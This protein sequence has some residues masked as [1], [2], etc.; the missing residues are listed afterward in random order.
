[1]T[2]TRALAAAL[3]AA[4]LLAAAS[5]DSA[6]AAPTEDWSARIAADG[7]ARTA[8]AIEALPAPSPEDR[9]ALGGV[10]FLAGVETMLQSRWSVGQGDAIHFLPVFRIPLPPNPTA[11]P[12][13]PAM[14]ETMLTA[15]LADMDATREALAAIPEG[16]KLRIDI[17]LQDLWFDV[18]GS[19]TPDP[20]ESLLDMTSP[21]LQT[22]AA[23][24]P[25]DVASLPAVTFDS[26]DAAWL[27]GY[28]HLLSAT[29]ELVLAF[30]PTEPIRRVHEQRVLM[31]E[32][33]LVG[34]LDLAF[35]G[36]E[37][38]FRTEADALAM[39][40]LSLRQQPLPERTRAARDHLLSM[41]ADNRRFWALA[42]AETDDRQE[43]IPNDRQTAAL[44]T[45]FPEGI[46]VAWQDVLSDAGKLL[47]GELLVP[48]WQPGFGFD[49]GG[50]L[51]DPGPV[52]LV[53]WL[54]GMG[55]RPWIRRGPLISGENWA[56][57]ERL[58]SGNAPLFAVWIN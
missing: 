54:H 45:D 30:S 53:E 13:D 32:D 57:F 48:I 24:V 36:P 43:W 10:R 14:I 52:D 26:A 20:A 22:Q 28:A 56:I 3:L 16:Q 27:S 11:E 35:A 15:L 21:A 47:T 37:G 18:N 42:N 50:W 6:A 8:A 49:L 1:M 41:M 5:F 7:L 25:G 9:F 31:N 19:N 39:A 2:R 12:F 58:A 33:G 44:G 4:A 55:M 51:E 29:A 17:R 34:P 23:E 46:D 38:D 40:I